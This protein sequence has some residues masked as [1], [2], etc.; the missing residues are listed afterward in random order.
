MRKLISILLL[1]LFA[2]PIFAT[3]PPTPKTETTL[4]IEITKNTADNLQ[5]AAEAFFNEIKIKKEE[6][7]CNNENNEKNEENEKNAFCTQPYPQTEKFKDKD[8]DGITFSNPAKEDDFKEIVAFYNEL[9]TF[10]DLLTTFENTQNS[11]KKSYIISEIDA[12]LAEFNLDDLIKKLNEENDLLNKTFGTTNPGINGTEIS[13]NELNNINEN[14]TKYNINNNITEDNELKLEK[15]GSEIIKIPTIPSTEEL[16]KKNEEDLRKLLDDL[17]TTSER[18]TK[19]TETAQENIEKLIGNENKQLEECKSEL[20]ELIKA[21]DIPENITLE[22]CKKQVNDE[23][24][25]KIQK[26]CIL[27]QLQQCSTEIDTLRKELFGD[28]TL[29]DGNPDGYTYLKES[30]LQG[31]CASIDN[32]VYGINSNGTKE[33]TLYWMF[34]P[35]ESCIKK[36]FPDKDI[37]ILSI[38]EAEEKLRTCVGNKTLLTEMS[39]ACTGTK[40]NLIE[41]SLNYSTYINVTRTSNTCS[42]GELFKVNTTS[43]IN[44]NAVIKQC[45]NTL[46]SQKCLDFIERI[47]LSDFATKLGELGGEVKGYNVN[48]PEQCFKELNQNNCQAYINA[49]NATNITLSDI[50]N[51]NIEK[52]TPEYLN[53]CQDYVNKNTLPKIENNDFNTL[54][55]HWKDLAKKCDRYEFGIKKYSECTINLTYNQNTIRD[56]SDHNRESF[57]PDGQKGDTLVEY[58][59]NET[60]IWKPRM[61]FKNLPTE[62]KNNII[63]IINKYKKYKENN[64]RIPQNNNPF[65]NIGKQFNAYTNNQLY[66]IFYDA[67]NKTKSN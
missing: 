45:M 10:K 44:E 43:K 26:G 35:D 61:K 5:S 18:I 51:T 30:K 9:K 53:E 42:T 55:N 28:D 11:K 23:E 31:N 20:E 15:H 58:W 13:E 12:I 46:K 59:D 34:K 21:S 3:T 27:S 24:N 33:G 63:N 6:Y 62:D 14:I 29:G 49:S 50:D 67:L 25:A 64:N 7:G 2:N 19:E 8:K 1:L 54:C 52:D 41:G 36:T 22:E 47:N 65:C 57:A 39:D 60:K 4:N 37:K 66:D 17:K 48:N 40:A 56:R 38:D 16:N 32:P